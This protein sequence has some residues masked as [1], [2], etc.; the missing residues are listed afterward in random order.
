[1][2]RLRAMGRHDLVKRFRELG[3][4]GPKSG[5]QHQYMVKGKRKVRIP[6]PHRGDT[7]VGLLTQILRQAGISVDEWLN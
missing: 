5:G 6:N 1:M 7:S 3:W 4:S 2:G